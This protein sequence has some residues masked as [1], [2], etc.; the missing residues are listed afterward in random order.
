[1]RLL[2]VGAFILGLG[3]L[4]LFGLLAMLGELLCEC[5]LAAPSVTDG[6]ATGEDAGQSASGSFSAILMDR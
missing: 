3:A 1:M 6:E 5:R 4:L 2:G